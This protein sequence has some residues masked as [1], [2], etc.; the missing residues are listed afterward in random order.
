MLDIFSYFDFYLISA[1]IRTT[2]FGRRRNPHD[3]DNEN[4]ELANGPFS[5]I[6]DALMQRNYILIYCHGKKMVAQV[7]AFDR[8]FNM[9]LVNV[10]EFWFDAA[11]AAKG[12]NKV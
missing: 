5:V 11:V 9:V 3:D 7:V 12:R 1:L 8:H 10:R 6:N 2:A 4:D